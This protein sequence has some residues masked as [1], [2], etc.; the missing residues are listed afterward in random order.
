MGDDKEALRILKLLNSEKPEDLSVILKMAEIYENEGD[1]YL[2]LISYNDA[3]RLSPDNDLILSKL[4]S[5]TR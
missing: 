1:D 3:L 5:L 2:A 4:A